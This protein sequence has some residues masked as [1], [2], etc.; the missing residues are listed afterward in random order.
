VN[1]SLGDAHRTWGDAMRQRSLARRAA[2]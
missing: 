1:V 2:P